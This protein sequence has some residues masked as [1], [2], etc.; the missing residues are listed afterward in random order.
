MFSWRSV[1]VNESVPVKSVKGADIRLPFALWHTVAGMRMYAD[2]LARPQTLGLLLSRIYHPGRY[3][4]PD[5]PSPTRQIFVLF[6]FWV[7]GGSWALGVTLLRFSQLQNTQLQNKPQKRYT[8]AGH[9]SPSQPYQPEAAPRLLVNN[10]VGVT[11]SRPRTPR[12]RRSP[13]CTNH[14]AADP[15]NLPT[16]NPSQTRHPAQP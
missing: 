11:P 7:S 15:A 14:P 5:L 2:L 16:K 1:S 10:L 13:R 9:H 4:R 3:S 8:K 12:H 6:V